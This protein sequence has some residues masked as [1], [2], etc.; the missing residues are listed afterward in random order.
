MRLHPAEKPACME[1]G[2]LPDFVCQARIRT[3]ASRK[4][5]PE[6]RRFAPDSREYNTRSAHFH[7]SRST[8]NR[9][10]TLTYA[11]RFGPPGPCWPP[12]LSGRA[13]PLTARALPARS[14][15]ACSK[16][17][18]RRFGRTGRLLMRMNLCRSD[19][20]SSRKYERPSLAGGWF[21]RFLRSDT[22]SSTAIVT[23]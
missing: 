10:F 1:V 5:I 18:V 2:P 23:R 22:T 12:S 3:C 8:L 9:R 14:S 17:P 7:E 21:S 6:V 11:E 4:S 20:R 19:Y 13:F 16:R 15:A